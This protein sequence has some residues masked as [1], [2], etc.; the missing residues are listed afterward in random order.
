MLLKCE[1]TIIYFSQVVVLAKDKKIQELLAK[2]EI[3]VKTLNEVAPIE[4]H[5]AKVLSYLYSN[6]GKT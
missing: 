3:K 4:V 2:H 6:L 1:V 5:P